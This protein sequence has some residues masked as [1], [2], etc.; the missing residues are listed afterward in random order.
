MIGASTAGRSDPSRSLRAALDAV[1]DAVLVTDLHGIVVHANTRAS[2]G[3]GI[4]IGQSIGRSDSTPSEWLDWIPD[5]RVLPVAD[6]AGAVCEFVVI[7]PMDRL[8]FDRSLARLAGTSV[9]IE[10]LSVAIA[11][12]GSREE[13]VL[14]TGEPGTGRE[15]V[16]RA[17]HASAGRQPSVFDVVE[18]ESLS[19]AVL[20]R[21]LEVPAGSVATV[22]LEE[23][24][25]LSR[26]AQR[27]LQETLAARPPG[28]RVMAG[29]SVDIEGRVESGVFDRELFYRL[30]AIR[31]HVPPLRER[32]ED[33]LEL[34]TET[35]R[36]RNMTSRRR[37]VQGLAPDAADVL[38]SYG[39]P[40]NARELERIVQGALVR[41]RGKQIRLD[42]L[43][44]SIT[45]RGR[46]G[47]QTGAE[48]TDVETL[49]ALERDYLMR[50]L[51][52]NDWRLQTVAAELGISRTTLWR[53]L[54]RLGIANP[55]RRSR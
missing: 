31:L 54:R 37:V 49:D 22:Y 3:L 20:A 50:V 42:H 33:V 53:R 10:R 48:R 26:S 7:V 4:S 41:C 23:V 39:F 25:A 29:A 35:I 32:P 44:E 51:G 9:A 8:A 14:V 27:V 1:T 40:G 6:E 13:P 2:D 52:D 28:L 24:D 55:R 45:R 18:A 11:S 34:A 19:A 43:P 30:N 46:R 36:R 38:A 15:S 21:R 16:A 47:R 5:R 12:A 17:I